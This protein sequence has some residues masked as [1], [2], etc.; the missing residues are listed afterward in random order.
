MR[1]CMGSPA[2]KMEIM[3]SRCSVL[4]PISIPGEVPALMVFML[5]AVCV[6]SERERESKCIVPFHV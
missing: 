2:V 3:I 4:D 1:K 5:E 6:A